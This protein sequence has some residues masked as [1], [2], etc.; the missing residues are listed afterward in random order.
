MAFFLLV[1]V[2]S[3][4]LP[5]DLL[6]S[7][8]I[9]VCAVFPSTTLLR[10][11][12]SWSSWISPLPSW[13]LSSSFPGFLGYAVFP[14]T[15]LFRL[16]LTWSPWISPPFLSTSSSPGFL[17]CAG[18]P[19]TSL[20]RLSLTGLP[21]LSLHLSFPGLY[22]FWFSGAVWNSFYIPLRLSSTW[23]SCSHPSF[24]ELSFFLPGSW[25]GISSSFCLPVA[26]LVVAFDPP[27]HP[28]RGLDAGDLSPSLVRL[29]LYCNPF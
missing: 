3:P 17:G 20:L 10:L 16:S 27:G 4:L 25:H 26:L 21:G 28:R 5:W 2:F 9:L 15:T 6:D 8:G 12:L 23:S 14:S 13:A 22:V 1:I 29:V 24:P 18:L 11:S 7:L 19:S